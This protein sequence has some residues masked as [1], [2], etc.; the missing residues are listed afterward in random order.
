MQNKEIHSLIEK[1]DTQSDKKAEAIIKKLSKIGP[2]AVPLLMKTAK[3]LENPRVQ[4]WSLQALGEM[5]DKKAASVLLNTL[6]DSRMTVRLHAI[7]GLSRMKL[8]RAVRPISRLLKDESGGI[9]VNALYALVNLNDPSTLGNVR[10]ALQDSQWYV[11]QTACYVCGHYE[12]KKA[13]KTLVQLSKSDTKKAVRKAA[14][15]ALQKLG[16]TNE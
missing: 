7:K 3:N 2:V 6:S 15:E 1:L 10:K 9:R 16:Y 4:K 14:E 11:R 5:G 8:K 12:D 13:L